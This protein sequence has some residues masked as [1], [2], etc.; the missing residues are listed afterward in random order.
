MLLCYPL[1]CPRS[2]P[3]DDIT[4]LNLWKGTK[5]NLRSWRPT[6]ESGNVVL[7]GGMPEISD[8]YVLVWSSNEYDF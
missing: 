3:A 8:G 2:S 7:G 1:L 5:Y 6:F 4:V